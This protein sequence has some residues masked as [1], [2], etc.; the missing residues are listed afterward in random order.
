MALPALL[1]TGASY[2]ATVQLT[3]EVQ[4]CEQHN[5]NTKRINMSPIDNQ[6]RRPIPTPDFAGA[7]ERYRD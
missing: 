5:K 7:S 4:L 6:C 3:I 2:D 1:D